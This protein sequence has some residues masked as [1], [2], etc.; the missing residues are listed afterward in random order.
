MILKRH[1]EMLQTFFHYVVRLTGGPTPAIA[2][3]VALAAGLLVIVMSLANRESHAL[4]WLKGIAIVALGLAFFGAWG[5][6]DPEI[7]RV[8][9]LAAGIPGL[10]SKITTL[11][12]QVKHL[13]TEN[14][15]LVVS[16]EILE[17]QVGRQTALAAEALTALEKQSKALA[18]TLGKFDVTDEGILRL[19][20]PGDLLFDLGSKELRC[21]NKEVLA[22]L[23]G[24]LIVK[25]ELPSKDKLKA[26]VVVGNTDNTP[27][28]T[29]EDRVIYNQRLSEDRAKAV[30]SYL[31]SNG[32]MKIPMTQIGKG[33][34]VP[35][36][37]K[38]GSSNLSLGEIDKLNA[39]ETEKRRNRRV[40]LLFVGSQ[41]ETPKQ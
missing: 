26:I 33:M 40:E 32:V 16:K 13:E 25:S 39:N 31:V 34:M 7:V 20:L 41:D 14:S 18:D 23:A 22:K 17:K 27:P 11:E 36:L 30:A 4:R 1:D 10:E 35:K 15:S 2:L 6:T 5:V 29:G 38:R 12:S 8:R 21:E 3:L 24:Y 37:S 28:K 9:A 19:T